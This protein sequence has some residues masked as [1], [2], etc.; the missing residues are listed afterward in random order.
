MS[1]VLADEVILLACAPGAGTLAVSLRIQ[2]ATVAWLGLDG[3]RKSGGRADLGYFRPASRDA[4]SRGP[5]APR[6]P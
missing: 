3:T 2:D 1:A 4:G 6:V 5:A